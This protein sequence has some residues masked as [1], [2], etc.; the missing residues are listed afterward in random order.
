MLVPLRYR[1]KPLEFCLKGLKDEI[2]VELKLHL[3]KYLAEIMDYVRIFVRRTR[4]PTKPL[5]NV[6]S[7]TLFKLVGDL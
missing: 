5:A 2:R 4:Y 6:T 3:A 1:H 7:Q